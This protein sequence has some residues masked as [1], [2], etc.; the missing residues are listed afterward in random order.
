MDSEESALKLAYIVGAPGIPV[1]GPSGSSAHVRGLA[2]AWASQHELRLYAA[3]RED[4]RGSFGPEVPSISTGVSGWPSWLARYREMREVLASR[5]LG[6]QL[7]QDIHGGWVPDVVVERHTLFSDVGWHIHD[8]FDIPWVLEVNAPPCIERSRFEE[9]LRPEWAAR[10]ERRVLQAAPRIVAVSRWLVRWLR[11]EMGC[12]DVSWVP[13]GVTGHRGVRSR[14]RALLGAQPEEPLI[15]FVGSPKPWHG[16]ERLERVAAACRARLVIIGDLGG[17][18]YGDSVYNPGHLSGQELADVVAALDVGMA[19]YPE[20]SPPWFCPLKI[21]DYR[22]QGTPVVASDVGDVAALV[23]NAGS[24]VAPGDDSTMIDAV[25][26]WLSRSVEPR[27]RSWRTVGRE[28]L[29]PLHRKPS[30]SAVAG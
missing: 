20:D 1:Q 18:Q 12:K 13:N 3:V 10:W 2:Q 26:W 8:R 23:E 30:S 17:H 22:A 24:V 16:V 5:R 21:L 27:V 7:I 11:D 15:G 9:L 28:V 25:K 4:R 14:G 6:R 19:P 29:G